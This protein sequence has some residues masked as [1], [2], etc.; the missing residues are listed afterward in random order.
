[1]SDSLNNELFPVSDYSTPRA[2]EHLDSWSSSYS[3]IVRSIST[4]TFNIQDFIAQ[5]NSE[6]L[7]SVNL[8]LSTSN[9][10]NA[11]FSGNVPPKI[12]IPQPKSTLD[13][14]RGRRNLSIGLIGCQIITTSSTS[15]QLKLAKKQPP[16]VRDW[17]VRSRSALA[18]WFRT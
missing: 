18:S 10:S 2:L 3:G 9:D 15:S 7:L 17:V 12:P 1:M 16:N 6:D 13:P 8:S 4:T 14:P 11:S 5:Q